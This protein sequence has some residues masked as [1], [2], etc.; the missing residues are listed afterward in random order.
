DPLPSNALGIWQMSDPT[1][2]NT[3]LSTFGG[4]VFNVDVAGSSNQFENFRIDDF[5]FEPSTVITDTDF[6]VETDCDGGEYIVTGISANQPSHIYSWKLYQTTQPGQTAGGVQLDSTQMGGTVSFAGL[7]VQ[8]YYYL[9]LTIQSLCDNVTYVVTKAI[10][11][12]EIESI[13]NFEDEY[14]VPQTTFCYGEDIFLDGAASFGEVNYWIGISRRPYPNN[15]QNWQDFETLGWTTNAE[16]P[17][18]NLSSGFANMAYDLEPGWE[19]NVKLAVQN[20]PACVNWDESVHTF[21]V[22]CC[23]D[24][25]DSKFYLERKVIS[26]TGLYALQAVDQT[27]YPNIAEEHTWTVYSS[28]NVDGGP[29]QQEAIISGEDFY[30]EV[31]E[32]LCYFVVHSLETLCGEWCYGQSDC[33]N[34]GEG[35]GKEACELCGPIDC[36]FLS[37]GLC[38]APENPTSLCLGYNPVIERLKWEAVA[39][40]S[41]YVVEITWNDAACCSSNLPEVTLEFQVASTY[42]DLN[43]LIQPQSDC[44][45]WL[46]RAVCQGAEPAWSDYQCFLGCGLIE[47]NLESTSNELHPA[48]L[49]P[50]PANSLV[51]VGFEKEFTGTL[52][53]VD[54]LGQV[55]QIQNVTEAIRTTFDLSTLPNGLY[56]IMSNSGTDIEAYKLIKQ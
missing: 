33:I 4:V 37:E 56:W 22:E 25:F 7:D 40:A 14:G 36:E 54:K 44:L 28:P 43:T 55:I 52:Q 16:V 23:E 49:Y 41:D 31:S 30:Y 20:V 13:F 5:C 10:P 50:N 21:V 35:F 42:L 48:T 32:G 29:Y 11:Y 17:I 15:G 19:Y 39:G 9:E 3:L 53:L 1:Q 26:G 27:V 12:Y 24:F 2:W 6:E 18:V 46:V 47:K 34:V 8:N 45:R 51:Y 38:L